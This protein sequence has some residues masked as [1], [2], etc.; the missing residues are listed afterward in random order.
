MV[1]VGLSRDKPSSAPRKKGEWW[2]KQLRN[3][4][5]GVRVEPTVMVTS[6]QKSWLNEDQCMVGVLE[7]G[8][9][10]YEGQGPPGTLEQHTLNE[11]VDLIVVFW[12]S[13]EKFSILI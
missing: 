4:V 7:R 6:S 13:K 3:Q 1:L 2:V 9:P 12:L 5:K 8:E 10:Y 11:S